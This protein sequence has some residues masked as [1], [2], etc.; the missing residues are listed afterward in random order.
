[1][2]PNARRAS[3]Q[4]VRVSLLAGD[5]H[6]A[7]CASLFTVDTNTHPGIDQDIVR[8]Q[9]A[10]P[11]NEDVGYVMQVIASAIGN[12][13]PPSAVVKALEAAGVLPVQMLDKSMAWKCEQVRSGPASSEDT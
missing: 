12:E 6:V 8:L 9:A 2:P 5:V 4:R 13:P 11:A 1:M 7:G 3:D 10:C